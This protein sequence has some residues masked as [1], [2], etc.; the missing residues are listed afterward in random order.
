MKEERKGREGSRGGEMGVQHEIPRVTNGQLKNYL[1]RTSESFCT[2]AV[3]SFPK[4]SDLYYL[5]SS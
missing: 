4:P 5:A 1:L 3:P 2:D